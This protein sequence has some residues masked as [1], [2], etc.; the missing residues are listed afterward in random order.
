MMLRGPINEEE[1]DVIGTKKNELPPDNISDLLRNVPRCIY[2][3]DSY[4]KTI[5]NNECVNHFL[6]KN[7]IH[8]IIQCNC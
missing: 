8:K 6:R 1:E 7:L 3:K 5:V 4:K 2:G